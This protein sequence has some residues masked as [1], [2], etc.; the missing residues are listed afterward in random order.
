MKTAL[1]IIAICEVVRAV[2]NAVQLRA[3]KRDTEAR[4]NAYAEF[5]KSL[6]MNDRQFV[7]RMLKEFERQEGET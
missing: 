5:V 1:W 3:I 6:K 7:E 2:Q 4:D